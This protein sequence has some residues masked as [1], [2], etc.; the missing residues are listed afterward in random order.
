MFSCTHR[1]SIYNSKVIEN[2]M[3]AA[4]GQSG[5]D[6]LFLKKRSGFNLAEGKKY[7]YFIVGVCFRS[8]WPPLLPKRKK[9]MT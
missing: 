5:H 4:V 7:Y 1:K 2:V 3:D 8:L 9:K 6:Q